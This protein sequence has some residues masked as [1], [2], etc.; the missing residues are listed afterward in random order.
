M[1]THT[2]K[3]TK[4]MYN[5]YSKKKQF[6]INKMNEAPNLSETKR[7]EKENQ[8]QSETLM[9]IRI[10]RIWNLLICNIISLTQKKPLNVP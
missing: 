3:T 9:T 1:Q 8:Y 5:F 6:K 4:M 7:M 2:Q 10:F